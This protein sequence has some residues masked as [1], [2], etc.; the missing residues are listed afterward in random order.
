MI[1][2]HSHYTTDSKNVYSDEILHGRLIYC[3]QHCDSFSTL[4]ILSIKSIILV[5]ILAL[6]LF[7]F[8][9]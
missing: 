7:F 4:T 5:V 2:V 6:I 1:K 9:I 8:H 3:T